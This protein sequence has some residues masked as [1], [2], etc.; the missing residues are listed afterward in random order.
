MNVTSPSLVLAVA[1]A[2]AAAIPCATQATTQSLTIGGSGA[3]GCQGQEDPPW[4]SNGTLATATFDFSYDAHTHVLDLVVANTSP[5]THGVPN[6]LITR[7]AFNLPH[8]AVADVTLL[9]QTGSGGAHPHLDL[10]DDADVFV[11][12]NLGVACMGDFGVLLS[13]P[14]IQGSIGNPLADTYAA[15]P[16]SVV[17][18]PVT[19]RMRLD[20][21]GV[22]S[23]SAQAIA[24]GFSRFA[25]AYQV[26]AACKFQGGGLHGDGIGFISSTVANVGCRPSGWITAA[27]RIGTTVGICLNGQPSCSGCFIGSLFPGPSIVGPFR[28]PIGLPL[29]FDFF[30]PPLPQNSL[31]CIRFDIPLDPGLIGRTL[32][33][34]VAT[35]GTSLDDLVDFSPRVNFTFID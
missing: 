28:L 23:L 12:P 16:G 25:P 27:P 31:L 9:S 4:L 33:L 7:I 22:D 35:P 6:P 20:G 11:P 13:V 5:V 21:P 10:Q 26:N 19:F 3:R 32:Y 30:I 17:I 29:L 15:P 34:A 18:G 8:H 2:L 24:V 14:N 1:C